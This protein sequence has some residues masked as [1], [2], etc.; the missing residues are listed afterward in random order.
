A[1]P[2]CIVLSFC[3]P[4]DFCS[5]MFFF[6]SIR[7]FFFRRQTA[8][9]SIRTVC[10]QIVLVSRP[11]DTTFRQIQ[12]PV[13]FPGMFRLFPRQRY[14]FRLISPYLM[15]NLAYI[16]CKEYQPLSQRTKKLCIGN[17]DKQTAP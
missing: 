5:R 13:Y 12:F 6:T 14:D 11:A 4:A 10:E 17:L 9:L 15:P 16:I 2:I 8:D 1:L 7:Y 3:Y